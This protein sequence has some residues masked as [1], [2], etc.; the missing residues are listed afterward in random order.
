MSPTLLVTSADSEKDCL[1]S[2]NTEL[3]II[4]LKF[5]RGLLACPGNAHLALFAGCE[6][7]PGEIIDELDMHGDLVSDGLGFF[8]RTHEIVVV[9]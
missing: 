9:G 8:P 5:P 2:P 4:Y 7:P 1:R 3:L 6:G